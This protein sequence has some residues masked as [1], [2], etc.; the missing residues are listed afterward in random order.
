M[1]VEIRDASGSNEIQV[2]LGCFSQAHFL[3]YVSYSEC[4]SKSWKEKL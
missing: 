4:V 1:D 3:V 2:N